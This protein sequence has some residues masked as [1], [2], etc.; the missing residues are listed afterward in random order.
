[1]TFIIFVIVINLMV[2]QLTAIKNKACSMKIYD[3]K[4]EI[5]I[6]PT[7]LNRFN[8]TA[9]IREVKRNPRKISISVL[10]NVL[11]KKS[12]TLHKE[13]ND[14]KITFKGLSLKDM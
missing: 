7:A 11:E 10:E 12:E 4:K 1:M 2:I 5:V 13:L 3:R 8:K 9:L 6:A 14:Y